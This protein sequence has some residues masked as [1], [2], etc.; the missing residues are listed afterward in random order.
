MTSTESIAETA[1][2]H[3]ERHGFDTSVANVAAAAQVSPRT[4]FRHFPTKEDA[5]LLAHR[6]NVSAFRARLEEAD[7]QDVIESLVAATRA[8]LKP[9]LGRELDRRRYR[10]IFAT[11]G[12]RERMAASDLDHLSLARDHLVPDLEPMTAHMVAAAG[13][14]AVNQ[15]LERFALGDS[16]ASC[17][18]TLS[19][20][21]LRLS[22][23][24]ATRGDTTRFV[25]VVDTDLSEQNLITR[26]RRALEVA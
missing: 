17:M 7:G 9:V 10:L 2:E 22:T 21:L 4:F 23:L 25:V 12:L 26:L 19:R 5:I 13:L 18:S 11:P 3:F 14:A 15:T 1:L 6:S 24:A 20:G 8:T 16:S